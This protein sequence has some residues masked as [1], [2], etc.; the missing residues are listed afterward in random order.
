MTRY[1]SRTNHALRGL[2][3]LLIAGAIGA[4]SA[5]A[6]DEGPHYGAAMNYRLNCEGCHQADGSGQPG[7]IPGFRGSVARFLATREGR[8]YLA[9]VPG[10]AQS[11]LSDGERA[12][13]LNWIITTFDPEHVPSNFAP[14]SGSELA[15]WRYDA[16]SQPGAIRATLVSQLN[17]DSWPAAAVPATAPATPAS[18]VADEPPAAFGICS[19]CHTVSKDGSNGV[20]PNLR[21]IIGRRAGTAAGFAYSPA[22]RAA[23]F[24][25]TAEQLDAY[26]K[27]PAEKVPGNFMAIA[28]IPDP[29][30]RQ[31]I[32]DYLST[33]R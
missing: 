4:A 20:G 11:L 21:G 31:S 6:R 1:D 23:G 22:M 3:V 27:A 12:E 8:T 7:F 13:V 5:A 25:W 24:T 18:T 10:T 2:L 30:N 26:L 28:G 15:P 29:A 9:R 33:L 16:L 32:I 17:A 19:A 14:Y